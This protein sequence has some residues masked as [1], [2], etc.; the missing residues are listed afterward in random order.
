MV[1]CPIKVPYSNH[2]ISLLCFFSNFEIKVICFPKTLFYSF[3]FIFGKFN[4]SV[5]EV[6]RCFVLFYKLFSIAKINIISVFSSRTLSLNHR[7]FAKYLIYF[8]GRF[9]F[10]VIQHGSIRKKMSSCFWN[11]GLYMYQFFL[12]SEIDNVVLMRITAISHRY[13]CLFNRLQKGRDC[14]FVC[15]F[16]FYSRKVVILV[17]V[18][19]FIVTIIS[20]YH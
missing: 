9:T 17:S 12:F 14:Q 13:L 1:S 10:Q 18:W 20:L 5:I 19:K 7:I 4:K 8:S 2:R 3:F 11:S 6:T 15:I 16:Y